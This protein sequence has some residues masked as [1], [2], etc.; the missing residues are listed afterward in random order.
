MSTNHHIPADAHGLYAYLL[1]YGRGHAAD[2]ETIAT[3]TNWPELAAVECARRNM[4]FLQGLP[5]SELEAIVRGDIDLAALAA[6]AHANLT[7]G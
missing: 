6:V 3:R 4:H 5:I 1:G 2:L 7:K